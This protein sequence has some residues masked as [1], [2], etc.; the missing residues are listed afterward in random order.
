MEEKNFAEWYLNE[1]TPAVV[2]ANTIWQGDFKEF[3][4]EGKAK[5]IDKQIQHIV[6]EEMVDEYRKAY[7]VDMIEELDAIADTLYTMSFLQY[8][9]SIVE[10]Q[11]VN[12]E[13]DKLINLDQ[14]DLCLMYND[15]FQKTFMTHFDLD[16]IIEATNRV[17]ENNN[18]KHTDDKEYF[19]T[20][21]HPKDEVL[22]RSSKEVDGVTYYFFVNE[23]GKVRKKDG[24]EIMALVDI[25]EEQINRFGM[26]GNVID[27]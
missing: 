27:E 7:G 13:I 3:S 10:D 22:E 8:Q 2:K 4:I 5:A 15:V 21:K 1:L 16:L 18:Q 14:L 25:V 12:D 26:S 11:G 6:M 9:L 20:W 17:V 23:V 19:D 24:F